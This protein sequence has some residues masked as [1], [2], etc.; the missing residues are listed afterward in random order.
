MQQ[1]QEVNER[2]KKRDMEM[3]AQRRRRQKE[4]REKEKLREA[5]Y[6]NMIDGQE[7]KQKAILEKSELKSRKAKMVQQKKRS[8]LKER[9]IDA[10]LREESIQAALEKK[11]RRDEY[12]RAA[13]QEKIEMDSMRAEEIKKQKEQLLQRRQQARVSAELQRKEIVEGFEK[14]K[15]TKK[16]K[17][18]KNLEGSVLMSSMTAAVPETN[19]RPPTPASTKYEKKDTKREPKPK[20]AVA[21]KV[22]SV[23]RTES[24]NV[25]LSSVPQRPT[26]A[27][28]RRTAENAQRRPGGKKTK[29]SPAKKAARSS[30]STQQIELLRRKQNQH[31]LQVLEEE[32]VAEEQR[33]AMMKQ[34]KDIAE[35]RRLEKIFGVERARAS[36]RIMRITEDH[37]TVL[38]QRMSDMGLMP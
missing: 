28:S 11:K 38:K 4:E 10:K 1:E 31:L 17:I 34:V 2:L 25:V 6:H 18:P 30:G 23:G 22:D 5:V 36:E 15:I 16:F 8:D 26:S 3:Q 20:K 32:Q 24:S 19:A 9:L 21:A 13:I 33:E 14:M 35:R 37:E 27:P 29:K 12:R 7:H